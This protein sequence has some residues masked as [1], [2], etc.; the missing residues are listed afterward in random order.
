M[1]LMTAIEATVI[2]WTVSVDT[3]SFY[4][5]HSTTSNSPPGICLSG[6]DLAATEALGQKKTGVNILKCIL[7]IRVLSL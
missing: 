5:K 4:T 7:Y 6:Q 3:L 2:F 1:H